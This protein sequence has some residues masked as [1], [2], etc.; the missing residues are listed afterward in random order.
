MVLLRKESKSTH[1]R[2]MASKKLSFDCVQRYQPYVF[3]YLFLNDSCLNSGWTDIW[4][5]YLASQV[6]LSPAL[7]EA[8]NK[9][10][11]GED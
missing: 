3:I 5:G 1:V 2:T 4:Q 7:P 9:C 6:S 8:K 11:Q 10:S